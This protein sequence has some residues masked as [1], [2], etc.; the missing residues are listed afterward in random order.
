M[1]D[2]G[3]RFAASLGCRR[4]GAVLDDQREVLQ[5]AQIYKCLLYI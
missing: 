1:N 5:V 3:L 2:G 4:K